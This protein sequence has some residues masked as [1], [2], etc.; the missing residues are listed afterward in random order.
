[1]EPQGAAPPAPRWRPFVDPLADDGEDASN[2]DERGEIF[3]AHESG[4]SFWPSTFF[5]VSHR[6]TR[7][8]YPLRPPLIAT[9][10]ARKDR[11]SVVRE[12][13]ERR[14][15]QERRSEE[16]RGGRRGQHASRSK[17][18]TQARGGV[19]GLQQ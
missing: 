8:A 13:V 14:V 2:S 16:A 4:S 17:R 19:P 15:G 11:K 1:M 3:E 6:L 10:I 12:R 9:V 5:A 18:Q 7:S